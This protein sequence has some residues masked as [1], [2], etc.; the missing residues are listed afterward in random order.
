MATPAVI[1]QYDLGNDLKIKGNLL[2]VPVL[3]KD[4][5]GV[6]TDPTTVTFAYISPNAG[7]VP[8]SYTTPDAFIT[9]DDVGEYHIDLDLVE[10][11]VYEIRWE[12]A[13]N[14]QGAAEQ[15]V[16]VAPSSF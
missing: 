8:V 3:I 6:L 13:G 11:G 15:K 10:E 2:R 1:Y 9:N 12:A 14:I 16:T 5:L 7:L 4:H